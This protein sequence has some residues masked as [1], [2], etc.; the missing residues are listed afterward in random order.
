MKWYIRHFNEKHWYN[1]FLEG[2]VFFWHKQFGFYA[3]RK[4]PTIY[5]KKFAANV[6]KVVV[7]KNT[8]QHIELL[9]I[10]DK[11]YYEAEVG[12]T[13]EITYTNGETKKIVIV[14]TPVFRIYNYI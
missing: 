13:L 12:D 3:M 5:L 4:S 2:K 8:G 6:K 10:K 1:I 11:I 7:L 14:Y 9:D